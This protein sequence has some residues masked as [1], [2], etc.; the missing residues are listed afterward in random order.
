MWQFVIREGDFSP[1]HTDNSDE[2]SDGQSQ[3]SD[4]FYC[5]CAT[6]DIKKVRLYNESNYDWALHELVIQIILFH[7][8]SSVENDLKMEQKLQ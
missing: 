7:C 3:A 1:R 2:V 6:T 5:T 8:A 4:I